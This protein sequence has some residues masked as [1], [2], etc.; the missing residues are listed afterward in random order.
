[1]TKITK[2]VIAD[3][4]C[5]RCKGSGTMWYVC[6]VENGAAEVDKDVCYCVDYKEIEITLTEINKEK[7]K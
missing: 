5:N 1:M 2:R 6:G 3:P 7:K 4:E